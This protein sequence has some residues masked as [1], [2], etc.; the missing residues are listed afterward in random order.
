MLL[1]SSIFGA[2]TGLVGGVVTAITN[3]KMQRLKNADAESQRQFEIQKLHAETDAMIREAEA[4]I[5]IAKTQVEGAVELEEARAFT[6]SQKPQEPLFRESYMRRLEKSRLTAWLVGPIA[7]VFALVDVLKALMRPLITVYHVAVTTWIT[8]LAWRILQ[9]HGSG[10]SPD[11]AVAIFDQVTT[12]VIY[13]CVTCVTWWFA[14]RRMAKFLMRLGGGSG[15]GRS[16]A[17][18]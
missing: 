15:A 12:T 9:E 11:K 14:D 8:V 4:N 17:P 1:S 7:L 2:V 16:D 5:K 13:L 18:F 3:Y 6:A 10:V